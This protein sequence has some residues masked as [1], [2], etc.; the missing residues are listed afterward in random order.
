[1]ELSP[2]RLLESPLPR[3][4]PWSSLLRQSPISVYQVM[5]IFPYDI[6]YNCNFIFCWDMVGGGREEGKEQ[7]EA[8]QVPVLMGASLQ[9]SE[10][11]RLVWTPPQLQHL[12]PWLTGVGEMV[13]N[14]WMVTSS[15]NSNH[16]PSFFPLKLHNLFFC[17]CWFFLEL[18]LIYLNPF[19][20]F[21]CFSL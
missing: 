4:L 13:N 5:Y 19:Y 3:S 9:V 21:H 18:L 17:C 10:T 12:T 16:T 2:W 7:V 15:D 8:D 20:S 6:C 14:Q 1:M 11:D